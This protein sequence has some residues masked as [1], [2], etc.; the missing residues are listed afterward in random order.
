MADPKKALEALKK[1][2]GFTTVNREDEDEEQQKQTAAPQATKPAASATTTGGRD[3]K[4]ALEALKQKYPSAITSSTPSKNVS[5]SGTQSATTAY[6]SEESEKKWWEKLTDQDE[7]VDFWARVMSGD[8]FKGNEEAPATSASTVDNTAKIRELLPLYEE[9][10]ARWK[11]ATVD[12]DKNLYSENA[13][14]YKAQVDDAK[15]EYESLRKQLTDL[16]YQVPENDGIMGELTKANQIYDTKYNEDIKA[17]EKSRQAEFDNWL[18]EE[19][20]ADSRMVDARISLAAKE[21]ELAAMDTRLQGMIDDLEADYTEE[22]YRAYVAEYAAFE[23]LVKDYNGIVNGLPELWNTIAQEKIDGRKTDDSGWATTAKTLQSGIAGVGDAIAQTLDFIMPTEFLGKYDPFTYYSDYTKRLNYDASNRLAE[24]LEGR[25]KFAQIASEIGVGLIQM[26][27]QFVAALY[28]GGASYADDLAMAASSATATGGASNLMDSVR[29]A[30]VGLSKN[31]GFYVS[32]AQTLGNDYD[33]AKA[34]GAT[35]AQAAAYALITTYLN[36]GVEV[37]GGIQTL[38]AALR[39]ADGHTLLKWVCSSTEEGLEEVVQGII[40]GTTA[41]WIYDP[42]K[43]VFSNT[44]EDAIIHPDTLAKEFGLGT[45]IGGIAGGFQ[46]GSVAAANAINERTA[47][48]AYT[49]A[50]QKVRDNMEELIHKGLQE[51]PKTDAYKLANELQA[52][53]TV[54]DAELGELAYAVQKAENDAIVEMVNNDEE[55]KEALLESGEE[56]GGKTA[57]MAGRIRQNDNRAS[58]DDVRELMRENQKAAVAEQLAERQG[59]ITQALADAK[60]GKKGMET[61]SSWLESSDADPYETMV[62]FDTPYQVGLTGV[63]ENMVTLVDNFQREAYNAGRM[64]YLARQA[65]DAKHKPFAVLTEKESGFDHSGVPADV[66]QEWR[67]FADRFLKHM[68]VKGG[69]NNN[70]TAYNAFFNPETGGADFAKDFGIDPALM[71]RLGSTDFLDKVERLAGQREESFLFYVA[72]EIAGHAAMD[73]A[74]APMRAF[75][76]AMYNYRQS[77]SGDENLARF[78]QTFYGSRNVS[79]DTDEAIEEVI[80]DSILMLYKDEKSFMAAMDR[81]MQSTDESAKKGARE[82]QKG[83]KEI[84]AKL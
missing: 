53:E 18:T 81:I 17:I 83:L 50:G 79:L 36:A 34:A 80:S 77:Q 45:A 28:T 42:D 27:P 44:N 43:E 84:I 62:R 13:F 10:D 48:K 67:N 63:E 58:I 7:H 19:T 78:K 23:K 26:A 66:P 55:S 61:F 46:V 37:S 6:S 54:T 82:Y 68:G 21:Q 25:G 74:R 71:K 5:Q 4:K 31:P 69:W 3:P 76:N 24:S 60:Y 11:Q 52:K 16:G 15:A 9:A 12:L 8:I 33:T 72:H 2:Y 1:K 73:R 57:E 20:E 40:S 49:E 51:D 65:E 32:A 75:A 22:G 29:R 47:Q 70:E 35:D 41:K 39:E 30:V 59:Q 14:A 64:D 56:F 38:P